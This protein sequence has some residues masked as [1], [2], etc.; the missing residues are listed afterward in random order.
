MLKN[1]NFRSISRKTIIY[2]G[3]FDPIHN[4]HIVMF[5]GF[6]GYILLP[7]ELE[8]MNHYGAV[9]ITVIDRF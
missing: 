9:G 1:D 2:P 3:T 4:G 6:L 7:K 5:S 8:K